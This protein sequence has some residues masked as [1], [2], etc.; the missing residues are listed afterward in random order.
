[1]IRLHRYAS[2]TAAC[3]FLL[4]IAGG[5]VTSTG[6]ALSVPDWPL[7]YGQYFPRMTGGV[8]FEHGHRM[9]A[10]IVGL[11][12][13]ALAVWVWLIE[14]RRWV[15]WLAAAAAG[16]IL[17]QALLGGITVLFSL[18]P[19]ISIAHAVL[20][21]TVFC[22][23]L[24]IAQVTSPWYLGR[25]SSANV[26]VAP[27]SI[28]WF[29]LAAVAVYTQLGLGAVVRHTGQHVMEH[30][31]MATMTTGIVLW[32]SIRTCTQCPDDS[33]LTRP[34][35]LLMIL[36]PLQVILGLCAFILRFGSQT[37]NGLGPALIRTSHLA[38]GAAILGVCV[39]L[40]LRVW[41]SD[42]SLS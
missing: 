21:Q 11:M 6:S 15:C 24:S 29:A 25:D 1:M 13:L 10:G 28:V 39:I 30:I 2:L 8:L 5:M 40:S 33:A 41:R 17:L 12:T 26:F 37:A 19:Q 23:I 38:C 9:I 36:I 7:A 27:F 34:A 31:L 4:L 22:L 42:E 32:N 3:A 18:P 35:G 14:K 16:G 20:G